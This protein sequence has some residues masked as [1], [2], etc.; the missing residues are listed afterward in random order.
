MGWQPNPYIVEGEAVAAQLGGLGG[1]PP[2]CRTTGPSEVRAQIFRETFCKKAPAAR[3][4]GSQVPAARQR[5][6][7]DIFM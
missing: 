7:R 6:G 2:R 1:R 4:W 3:Q 5:G